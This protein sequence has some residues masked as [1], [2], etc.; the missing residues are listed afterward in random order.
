MA[1]KA[2]KAKSQKYAILSS[3]HH[4]MRMAIETSGAFSHEAIFF[5]SELGHRIRAETSELRSL[6]FL[7]QGC[8]L[9]GYAAAVMGTLPPSDCFHLTIA[10]LGPFSFSFSFTPSYS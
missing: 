8:L 9:C 10:F 7:L 6:Q 3:S 1:S 5:I 4:F 2:E